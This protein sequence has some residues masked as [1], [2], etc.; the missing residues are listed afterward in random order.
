MRRRILSLLL[1]VLACPLV[2]AQEFTLGPGDI[3][4]ITVFEHPDLETRARVTDRGMINFPLLGQ[5]KIGGLSGERAEARL[6]NLLKERRI[7]QAPQVLL[8]VEEYVSHQVAILGKVARPGKYPITR[9]STVVDLLAEAGGIAA[10]G[11]ESVLVSRGGKPAFVVDVS[12]LMR[13]DVSKAAPALKA[14]DIIYVPPVEV[15]YI[16]GEVQRPGEYPLRGPTTVMQAL[17]ISGGLTA[18]G[19]ER[20][21]KISRK[22]AQGN[23]QTVKVKLTDELRPGDVV[24]VKEGLL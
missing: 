19:T 6:R 10:N 17:S 23:V 7:V 16:Y 2:Q 21:L 12:S 11:S 8:L 20:G 18:K 5:V 9:A 24:F 22:N 13:G 4:R 3:V 15:F 1:I 14:N